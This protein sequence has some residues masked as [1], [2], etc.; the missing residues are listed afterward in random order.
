MFSAV[1]SNMA[2]K[3]LSGKQFCNDAAFYFALLDV[4][5]EGYSSSLSPN[6]ENCTF[7]G[8]FVIVEAISVTKYEAFPN[9]R[10]QINYYLLK[11]FL[12]LEKKSVLTCFHTQC[13]KMVIIKNNLNNSA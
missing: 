10:Y 7:T 8:K 2:T 1:R 9:S 6:S 11:Q 13:Y 3:T 4:G 12:A 5:A